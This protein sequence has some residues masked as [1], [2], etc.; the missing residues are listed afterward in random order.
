M[1]RGPKPIHSVSLEEATAQIGK[2][3]H[4]LLHAYIYRPPRP[5]FDPQ[6]GI[7]CSDYQLRGL[8]ETAVGPETKMTVHLEDLGKPPVAY[9]PGTYR[10]SSLLAVFYGG[11]FAFHPHL[12]GKRS[13]FAAVSSVL[14]SRVAVPP[15]LPVPGSA[16]KLLV[17]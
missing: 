1:N 5:G 2:P 12:E 16:M 11:C 9:H 13:L 17:F 8:G 15:N 10:R 14:R 4:V 6:F 3:S 7:V